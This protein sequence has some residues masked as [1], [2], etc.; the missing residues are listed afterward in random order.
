MARRLVLTGLA[1]LIGAL[2]AGAPVASAGGPSFVL[3]SGCAFQAVAVATVTGGQ[4][5]FAGAARGHAVFTDR[6]SHTLRCYVAVDGV[7][8]SSTPEVR[9]DLSVGTAGR[10]TY[11]A[12]EG[13]TTDLCTVLDGVTVSCRAATETQA[14]PREPVDASDGAAN[15]AP[16][17]CI[18]GRPGRQAWPG[19]SSNCPP[20]TPQYAPSGALPARSVRIQYA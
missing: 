9:A 6:A 11:Y 20:Y 14:V 7:E 5:T 13:A 2:G 15:S 8:Q 17:H 16:D 19:A 3:R 1:L 18:A 10:V 12:A 4:Q